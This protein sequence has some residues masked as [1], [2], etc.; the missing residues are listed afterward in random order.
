MAFD[1]AT[2]VSQDGAGDCP[3]AL[4]FCYGTSKKSFVV[5]A[6]VASEANKKL[7][8]TTCEDVCSVKVASG[9]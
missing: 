9:E 1:E 8:G 4:P 6:S 3:D 7:C 5:E 2:I